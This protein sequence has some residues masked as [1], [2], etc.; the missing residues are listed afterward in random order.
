MSSRPFVSFIW[1]PFT[2]KYYFGCHLWQRHNRQEHMQAQCLP[3]IKKIA[4]LM[5]TLIEVSL[6]IFCRRFSG[7]TRLKFVSNGIVPLLSII[8]ILYV[9]L[10]KFVNFDCCVVDLSR[11]SFYNNG[12]ITK[13]TFQ[14]CSSQDFTKTVNVNFMGK[15]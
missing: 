4:D 8:L 12:F 2:S 5:P 7:F 15:F 14:K 1:S 13:L 10:Q 9:K 3:L 11:L 6:V